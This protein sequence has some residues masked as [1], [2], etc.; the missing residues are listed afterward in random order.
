MEARDLLTE[1]ARGR[2]PEALGE[3]GTAESR[4]VVALVVSTCA[5]GEANRGALLAARETVRAHVDGGHGQ[6]ARWMGYLA[7]IA[8]ALGEDEEA[9]R[10]GAVYRSLPRRPASVDELLSR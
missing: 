10:L 5:S 3:G 4:A 8:Q 2:I 6:H 7:L 1:R 9:R